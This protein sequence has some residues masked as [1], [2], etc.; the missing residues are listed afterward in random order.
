[1][2][3]LIDAGKAAEIEDGPLTEAEFEKKRVSE[4]IKLLKGYLP[5][6][7]VDNDGIYTVLSKGVHELSEEECLEY[8]TPLRDLMFLLLEED[9]E[10]QA[11]HKLKSDAVSRLAAIQNKQ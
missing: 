3:R 1:M 9:L 10:E 8:F 4:R 11:K 5:D 2:E 6:I 7:L